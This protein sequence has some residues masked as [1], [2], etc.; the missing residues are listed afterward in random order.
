[1]PADVA[2]PIVT[3]LSTKEELAIARTLFEE[4]AASLGFSLAFQRFDEELDTL[5][6]RYAPPSGTILLA[7]VA[8][9]V[10]G[11]VALRRLEA[12][13]CEM[14]RLYVR[15][16]FVGRGAGRALVRAIVDEARAAGYT[17]M[18][19]D[20]V[21]AMTPA[22][23]LYVSLGF[24]DIAPYTENPIDGARFFELRL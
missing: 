6:G 3:P 8:G 13:I 19:L 10:A 24:R 22:I 11:C 16:R 12:G 14:K 21:A 2:T 7:R 9:E 15:P 20:T 4:Y 1:M 23:A 17:A 18:R 5:P